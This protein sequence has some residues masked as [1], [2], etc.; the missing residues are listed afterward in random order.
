M[1]RRLSNGY[2][3]QR[4]VEPNR[5]WDV[6]HG[7]MFKVRIWKNDLG[8]GRFELKADMYH[9]AYNVASSSLS[10]E[11]L[12]DLHQATGVALKKMHRFRVRQLWKHVI[13]P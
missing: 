10:Y 4:K 6:V 12:R 8:K 13:F 3:Q 1:T 2:Y 7:F 5:P 11:E 9:N